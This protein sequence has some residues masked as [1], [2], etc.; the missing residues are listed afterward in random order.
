M[1]VSLYKKDLM[2]PN[3]LFQNQELKSFEKY[4]MLGILF[5]FF[6]REI[7]HES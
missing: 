4:P 2:L 7:T 5:A 6:A 1:Y 3:K